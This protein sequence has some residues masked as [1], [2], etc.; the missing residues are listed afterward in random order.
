MYACLVFLVLITSL[1]TQGQ[2]DLT[3]RMA[4]VVKR[5]VLFETANGTLTLS[6]HTV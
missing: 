3:Y 6:I 5:M 2:L 4:H 1:I